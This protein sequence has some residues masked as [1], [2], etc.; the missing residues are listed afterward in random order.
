M[1]SIKILLIIYLSCILIANGVIACDIEEEKSNKE[2]HSNNLAKLTLE[3]SLHCNTHIKRHE[4]NKKQRDS[5]ALSFEKIDYDKESVLSDNVEIVSVT[6]LSAKDRKYYSMR[7]ISAEEKN[8][9]THLMAKEELKNS[10][11]SNLDNISM[12]EK[13]LIHMLNAISKLSP[14]LP[15]VNY[16]KDK[17]IITAIIKNM[18][19]VVIKR[20]ELLYRDRDHLKITLRQVL[21]A[22]ANK[23]KKH[24]YAIMNHMKI[25]VTISYPKEIQHNPIIVHALLEYYGN[26][27]GG[28]FSLALNR[29]QLL[30]RQLFHLSINLKMH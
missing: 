25:A 9:K 3:V 24:Q 16:S 6:V 2:K 17:K 14:G 27:L 20:E 7:A 15:K 12:K 1:K 10:I 11:D 30:I 28:I 8:K 21:N 13:K 18:D 22:A 19:V 23:E 4:K 5:N 29:F 26:S